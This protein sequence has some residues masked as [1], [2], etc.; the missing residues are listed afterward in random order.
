[1]EKHL[2]VLYLFLCPSYLAYSKQKPHVLLTYP[3]DLSITIGGGIMHTIHH[4]KILQQHG[5]PTWIITQKNSSM[6]QWCDNHEIPTIYFSGDPQRDFAQ[7][8]SDLSI[9]I[10]ITPEVRELL[11]L[12]KIKTIR[13]I[14]IVY[15][16]HL[17]IDT[18]VKD[19]V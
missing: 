5:Y 16:R 15:V 14:K 10:V 13:P 11:P 9:D 12:K 19:H 17:T 6:A 4:A 3:W 18:F 8:C 2:L 7:V 1:M